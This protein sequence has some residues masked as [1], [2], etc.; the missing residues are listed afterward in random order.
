MTVV[1]AAFFILGIVFI[2]SSSV[3]ADDGTPSS[4][5]AQQPVT[6]LTVADPLDDLLN[7]TVGGY[8]DSLTLDS[9]FNT[10]FVKGD[11]GRFRQD[12][13]ADDRSTG[14]F[15]RVAFEGTKD[16]VAYEFEGRFVVDYDFLSRLQ[17]EKKDDFYVN[18]EWKLFRKYWDGSQ[19]DPFD[20]TPYTLPVTFPWNADNLHTDRG[21]VEIEFGK[22]LSE[23]AKVIVKYELWTRKGR[24]A[25]L[26]GEQANRSNRGLNILR[27]LSM[28]TRV[29][30]VSNTFTVAVPFTVNEIHN[31]EPSISFE[32]YKD[33]QFT[34][35]AR[36]NNGALNQ[37]RD[38]IEKPSFAD[39]RT[40]FKYDS[41]LSDNV[42]VHGGYA[43]NFLENDSTRSEVR[44]N[45]AAPNTYVNPD[46]DNWRLSNTIGFG[47]ALLDFLRQKNL[48][49]RIGF[50][51]EH[52]ITKAN[53]TLYAGLTRRDSES[54]LNEG[55][56]GEAVSLTY[57]GI[58]DTTVFAGLD[59]EQRRLRWQDEYDAGSH[60]SVTVFG[61]AV[62]LP[63]YKTDIT[64]ID[65]V[66]RFRIAH[67]FNS[68]LRAKAEYKWQHKDRQYN[69]LS[70]SDP[71]FYPGI[72]G[73][74][75]RRVHELTMN[76]DMKLPG[77]WTSNAKY[78][79]VLDDIDFNKVGN[80][81]QDADRHRF[82]GT[83]SGPLSQQMFAF[84]TG[85]Y[86]FY[87]VDTP[88]NG[89]GTNRWSSG[90]SDYDFIGDY[91]LI[92]TNLNYRVNNALSS[93]FSYQATV[94]TGDNRNALNEFLLG[95]KYKFSET[96]SVDCRYQ[97]FNFRD[98]RGVDGGYDDDYYGQ[99][100]AFA[101]TKVLG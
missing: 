86:E 96:T 87:R 11:R 40:Q 83:V 48:D 27:S 70:D 37:R 18:A 61:N 44:P 13:N 16:D 39:L 63:S 60:E 65:I 5:V 62:L 58:P 10:Y 97:V 38:Y 76:L 82:S 45:L 35:S 92:A 64:F 25:L 69:T 74:M 52:A 28:R 31:F 46:V 14:G 75:E 7:A 71:A 24:E 90:E 88:A 22:P 57:R 66:P 9:F 84:L 41:F 89:P 34:D 53:G 85:A 21:N 33:S 94:S 2:S 30:G 80:N 98:N 17:I 101:I 99:G 32:H 29:D 73:D 51:G 4:Q 6:H 93:Y 95:V 72:L 78:Q 3:F 79:M 91:F 56:F 67:R 42:Y 49:V 59:M 36:Y 15:K 54:S 47:T 50:R 26:K 77:A 100:L 23:N 1:R 20:P 81:Q 12:W 55:W 19:D 8:L 68:R 43:L